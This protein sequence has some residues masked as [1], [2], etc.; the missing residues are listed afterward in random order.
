MKRLFPHALLTLFLALVWLLLN[1]TLAW[2]QALLGL[3]LGWLIPFFSRA[4]WPQ[5]VRIHRPRVLLVF[6]GYVILDIVLAN[7]TVARLILGSPQKLHPAFVRIP[8]ALKHE[9]AISILANTICLTPGTLSARL[10][11]DRKFLLVH[12]LNARDPDEVVH[13]I[14]QR[15]ETRLMEIFEC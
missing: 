13:S 15:Y 9:L 4:F 12:A 10:S 3:L 1:N 5:T 14:K 2:G 8:L 6:I 7:L 11:P